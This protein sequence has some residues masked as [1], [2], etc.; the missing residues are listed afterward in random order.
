MRRTNKPRWD[1]RMMVAV[2]VGLAVG[3]MGLNCDQAAEST[4]R[5][6][7]TENIAAGVK[8]IVNG[9]IDGWAAAIVEA[10][11]DGNYT[12]STSDTGTTG[13]TSSGDTGTTSADAS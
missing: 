12:G 9:M 2:L 5:L 13:D 10:G 8:Q 6:T 7:A 4:F 11:D 3:T 1:G